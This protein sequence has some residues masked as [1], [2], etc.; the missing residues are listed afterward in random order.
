MSV[1]T[2]ATP[3]AE[4]EQVPESYT[5]VEPEATET[6]TTP[7]TQAAPSTPATPQLDEAAIREDERIRVQNEFWQQQAAQQQQR[8]PQYQ[9]QQA[10]PA[11]TIDDEI[12]DMLLID[13][14]AAVQRLRQSIT[15][16]V[17]QQ[18]LAPRL[19]NSQARDALEFVED[20]IGERL[21]PDAKRFIHSIPNLD[22]NALRTNETAKDLIVS[23]VL[24]KQNTH[25]A[26]QAKAETRNRPEPAHGEPTVDLSASFVREQNAERVRLNLKPMTAKEMAAAIA[27][28]AR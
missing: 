26:A 3:A 12:A 1:E 25:K 16:Q 14:R 10:Q 28:N 5:G 19:Q 6:P 24:H 4:F 2:Q 18:E 23:A 9:Q 11:A 17:V 15:Q 20:E 22:V 27:R 8:Q 13:P 21:S 7:V